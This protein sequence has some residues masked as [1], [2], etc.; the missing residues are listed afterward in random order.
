VYSDAECSELVSSAGTVAVSNGEA[1][2]SE[3]Q[4]IYL[5]GTYYWQASYSGDAQNKPSV[6]ACGSEVETV[7]GLGG[8]FV[9]GSKAATMGGTVTFWGAQWWKL[10]PLGSGLGPASFK[11][12]ESSPAI[13]ACGKTWTAKTGNSTP[14]PPGPLPAF[15]PVIVSSKVTQSGSVISG[16]TVHVDLVKVNPGYA[17]NPGHA[18][19]GTI[20]SQVC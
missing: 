16:N 15:I 10:N 3:P 7:S 2:A 5:P 9:I 18:G 19:T 8:N 20:V 13:A 6:S 1:A 4:T 17:P 11:G 12:F 14:P